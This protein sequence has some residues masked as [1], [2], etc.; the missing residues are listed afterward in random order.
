MTGIHRGIIILRNY[1]EQNSMR[2]LLV[3]IILGSCN[4]LRAQ[5]TFEF[6][7]FDTSPRASGVGGSFVAC[8]D[9]PDVIFHN[10]A[11]AAFLQGMPASFN[12]TKHLLDAN[13]ASIAASQSFEGLGRFSAGIKYVNYGTFTGADEFGNK[14]SDFSAGEM[15]VQAGYANFLD[16]NFAYG[17]AVKFIYSSIADYSSTAAAFDLGLNY[18][19]PSERL[20]IGFAMLHAGKQLSS[21]IATKEK[22]PF[23]IRF[24][25][26]KRLQYLPLKFYVDF[27]KLS[28]PADSFTD[29]FKS[30]TVGGEIS[31]NK[32][33][34]V[35]VGFDNEKRSELKVGNYAGLAG[36]NVGLGFTVKDYLFNYSFSSL[37]Q[38]GSWHRLGLSL[39]F[40][41]P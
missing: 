14:T 19:F 37:G 7:R 15:V 2:I 8:D 6:L 35:R 36:F 39:N 9:D 41:K 31:F 21:Y 40:E 33:L 5:S 27:H 10:P 23:E 12:F 20:N 30:F 22:L 13:L 25:V 3:L 24:G 32:N 11:G 18:A 38:I 1:F 4:F 28:D 16:E 34:R 17:A 26:T 29:K